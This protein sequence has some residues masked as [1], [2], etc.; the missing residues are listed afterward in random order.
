MW[1]RHI[2][3]AVGAMAWVGVAWAAVDLSAV[4]SAGD[5]EAAEAAYH[6]QLAG[7]KGE[8]KLALDHAMVHRMADLGRPDLALGSAQSLVTA[9]QA[10]ATCWSVLAYERA[11]HGH[12]EAALE[13]ITHV[14]PDGSRFVSR[15]AAQVLALYDT[16]M[17]K[18]DMS[19]ELRD[20]AESVR[21]DFRGD[22][23]FAAAYTEAH[24]TYTTPAADSSQNPR[25]AGTASDPQSTTVINNYNYYNG[26]GEYNTGY[27]GSGFT[28]GGYDYGWPWWT[29]GYGGP[30]Y[31]SAWYG[32][33]GGWGGGW[34][35]DWADSFFFGPFGFDFDRRR[36]R[37]FDD[38]HR[39]DFARRGEFD[40]RGDFD[41]RSDFGQHGSDFDRRL[42][43]DFDRRVDARRDFREFNTGRREGDHDRRVEHGNAFGRG[44]VGSSGMVGRDGMTARRDIMAGHTGSISGSPA[45]PFAAGNIM[46]HFGTS[47]GT[48]V[49]V[50]EVRNSRGQI[51]E[52]GGWVHVTPGGS[53][54]Y[55]EL[56][57]ASPLANNTA[58]GHAERGD[59]I[60]GSAVRGDTSRVEPPARTHMEPAIP[61]VEPMPP[62]EPAVPR[63]ELAI[64]PVATPRLTTPNRT[65]SPLGRTINVPPGA[66]QRIMTGRPA[67]V[68]PPPI[69]SVQPAQR[70]N[71]NPSAERFNRPAGGNGGRAMPA[72]R[73]AGSV[74]PE[75]AARP[76]S[77]AP[78]RAP[79]GGGFHGGSGGGGFHGGSSGGH[80][81]G[82]HGGGGGGHGGGHR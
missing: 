15:T 70:F 32:S 43:G 55:R 17:D 26:Q 42:G 30:W 75:S 10:D 6:H 66:A 48:S 37:H 24:K 9:N 39:H 60:H 2:L 40:R 56:R 35:N 65:A 67:T 16:H 8:E 81:G 3:W 73:G 28:Y 54:T 53:S 4:T 34:W 25:Q 18:A 58:R 51:V 11:Y 33:Y 41:R 29:G 82:G 72:F 76:P 49:M 44:G 38:F 7:A 57:N 20:A 13:A 45:S 78:S 71:N 64:P 5:A 68:A 61:R 46:P 52:P 1:R 21:R 36:G 27:D 19:G 63:M 80:S 79:T 69:R 12:D 62:M 47:A 14:K 31:N 74:R 59:T 22:T 50:P 23:V 77:H